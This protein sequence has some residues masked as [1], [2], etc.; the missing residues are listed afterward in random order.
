MSNDIPD[1]LFK[2]LVL[3]NQYR[4]LSFLNVDNEDEWQKAVDQ[5]LEGWPL[6]DL[7]DVERLQSY[8]RDALTRE[9]QYFVLDALNVFELIQDGVKVGYSPK[10]ERVFTKFPGFG[11]NNES[12][13][14]AYLKHLVEYEHR[15]EYVERKDNRFNSHFPMIEFYQRIISAWEGSVRPMWQPVPSAG[16]GQ[17]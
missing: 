12:K 3:A 6:E 5:S 9:D 17:A 4:I 16:S 13:L 1:A 15:F 14:M 8:L 11:G 10:F 2:R 7:P